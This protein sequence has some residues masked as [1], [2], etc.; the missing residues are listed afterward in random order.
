VLRVHLLK[1]HHRLGWLTAGRRSALSATGG[2][3]FAPGDRL[4]CAEWFGEGPLRYPHPDGIAN[5]CR[6]NSASLKTNISR[7]P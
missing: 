3:K 7:G 4:I 1:N 5:G 2:A 6:R